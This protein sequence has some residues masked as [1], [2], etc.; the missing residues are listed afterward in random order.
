[1]LL[2]ECASCCQSEDKSWDRDGKVQSQCGSMGAPPQLGGT[3]DTAGPAKGRGHPAGGRRQSKILM[4]VD[5]KRAFLYGKT[6]RHVYIKLPAED[7]RSHEK[8]VLGR[9]RKAMY[10]TRDAPQIW[11]QEVQRTMEELGFR[12]SRSRPCVYFND[13]LDVQVVAHVDDF[14]LCG[15]RENLEFVYEQLSSR[16]E[17]KKVTVGPGADDEKEGKFLG[18]RIVWG[19]GGLTYEADPK[20]AQTIQTIPKHAVERMFQILWG[21]WRN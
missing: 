19:R 6:K 5:V 15:G 10:G 16:F 13:A 11:Q 4:I 8:G 12:T 18:R 3:I 20:H 9:L 7:P 17:L 2:S 1:M 21:R 14:L